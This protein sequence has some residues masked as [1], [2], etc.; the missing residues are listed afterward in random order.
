MSQPRVSRRERMNKL[1]AVCIIGAFLF[2]PYHRTRLGAA[3]APTKVVIHMP[4]SGSGSDF[5][6]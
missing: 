2:F 1:L 3:S 6:F 5:D 4:S